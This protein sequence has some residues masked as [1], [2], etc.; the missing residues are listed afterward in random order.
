MSNHRIQELTPVVEVAPKPESDKRRLMLAVLEEA[1]TT[2]Q[3]G[4]VSDVAERRKHACE[5][6]TWVASDAVDWPFAFENVCDCLGI[7][8]DYVRRRMNTLRRSIYGSLKR[9]DKR[10][11]GVKKTHDTREAVSIHGH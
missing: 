5:V 4:L 10:R 11:A 8:P 3:R 6:E 1:L 7:E 9:N 2:F